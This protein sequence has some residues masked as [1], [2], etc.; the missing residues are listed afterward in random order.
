MTTLDE[1]FGHHAVW[2]R[3]RRGR[4]WNHPVFGWQRD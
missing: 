4:W 2:R 1:L 3:L